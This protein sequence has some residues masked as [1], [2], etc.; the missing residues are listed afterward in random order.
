M[1]NGHLSLR[2]A[3]SALLA[4]G[5]TCAFATTTSPSNALALAGI[6][7]TEVARVT[8]TVNNQLVAP[9]ARTHLPI[10][11]SAVTTTG[12]LADTT[13]M[14]H[15]QLVLKPSAQR[16]A[17]LEQLVKAQHDPASPAFH[18]WITPQQYG[19]NF[20]VVDSDIAAVSAWLTSQGFVVNA[21]Y[22][23][24]SQIDFSGTA[25]QV[26]QAF[27]TQQTQFTT[28][29]G[30]KFIANS[31]DISVP[32]A[33]QPVIAG[34]LGLN[35][36]HPQ[37]YITKPMIGKFNA[38]THRFDIGQGGDKKHLSA[39]GQPQGISMALQGQFSRALV[40]NDFANMYGVVGPAGKSIRDNGI[41][42]KGITIAVVEDA[43]MQ[44]GDWTNFVQ[45][46]NLGTYGG[47]F[48]QFQPQASAAGFKNCLEPANGVQA[49]F[50]ETALDAEYVTAMAPGAN[51]WVAACDSF[52]NSANLFGGTFTAA[53]NLVNA[54]AR[55][56][57]ISVSWGSGEANVD[58]GSKTAI[59]MMWAQADAEGISVFV[60]SG[61]S[62]SNPS[63]NGAF[64]Y[65][66]GIDANAFGSSPHDTA[67]GGTDTADI[68]DGTTSSY[69]NGNGNV[70]FGTAKGYVPEIPWNASCGN[71]IVAKSVWGLTS[72]ID[73]C[74]LY[75]HADPDGYTITSEASSGG[76]SSVDAKP[77]WQRMVQNAAQDQSRDLPDVA[78]FAGSYGE[79]T[80]T[81]I[82]KHF[83]PCSPTF[84]TQV[85]TVEGT[86]LSA[87]LM[88]GI[89]ALIDQG[90]A[91]RGLQADQGNS[92]PTLYALA[93]QEY[94][95]GQGP[96]PD[97]LAACA[98]VDNGNLDAGAGCVFHN[99]VR[100]TISS[101]CLTVVDA[102]TAPTTNCYFYG[103]INNLLEDKI[104]NLG[105]V[106][107]GLTSLD[108]QN[109]G[110]TTKA[111]SAQPG[112]SFASGLGS[113]N[114]RNLLVAWRAF[115]NA[116]AASVQ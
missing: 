53:D 40:P 20:G 32:S 34:V 95:T 71:G 58:G 26:K 30:A 70:D 100:G 86:S 19:Q 82:C 65:G 6:D 28:K 108:P 114:A 59:D 61:D 113:V 29:G 103:G 49:D 92:A 115:V 18:Q 21:V 104:F 51:V 88:A 52:N 7:T 99:I 11:M 101:Q 77:A 48:K 78:L 44:P 12:T 41:T 69:F 73:L 57:I 98:S 79:T 22:P 74:K 15:M 36:V 54:A 111:Y 84:S 106:T 75:L 4:A 96:V 13:A 105:P 112:W 35:N 87:P 33:L 102:Q 107:L 67:V 76:P 55:P 47:T 27:H 81:V 39:S 109:Y 97:S 66:Q 3:I 62:G 89:Q 14:S 16:A 37:P 72:A 31:T 94:G 90:I 43:E 56:D 17:A 9:L 85:E 83:Y 50:D 45:T 23:N 63:Y 80:T 68:W 110:P 38:G 116:P 5:S 60:S 10:R 64:I 46:F 8:Q 25:G 24:K 42:G 1:K 93:G 91:Q 2:A